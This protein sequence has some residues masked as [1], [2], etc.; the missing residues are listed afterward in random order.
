MGNYARFSRLVVR[1]KLWVRGNT[2]ASQDRT[3]TVGWEGERF[4]DEGAV[5]DQP[6]AVVIPGFV[7]GKLTYGGHC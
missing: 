3:L 7:G 6:I 1:K 5:G 2:P 4:M